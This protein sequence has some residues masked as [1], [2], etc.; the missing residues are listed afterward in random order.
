MENCFGQ[1]TLLKGNNIPC[2]TDEAIV[3]PQTAGFR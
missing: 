1:I 2:L 3:P